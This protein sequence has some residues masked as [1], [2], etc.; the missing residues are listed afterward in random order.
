MSPRTFFEIICFV[1]TFCVI[2]KVLVTTWRNLRRSR[3]EK[4]EPRHLNLCHSDAW[5]D[6]AII[7]ISAQ[8]LMTNHNS[9]CQRMPSISILQFERLIIVKMTEKKQYVPVQTN[10][11]PPYVLFGAFGHPVLCASEYRSTAPAN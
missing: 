2:Q 6:P 10:Y 5:R 9:K 8:T 7:K 11:H 1:P 3:R 4:N